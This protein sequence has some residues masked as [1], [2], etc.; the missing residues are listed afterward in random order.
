MVYKNYFP[1]NEEDGGNL[2]FIAPFVDI[3]LKINKRLKNK[4]HFILEIANGHLKYC[5]NKNVY[6]RTGREILENLLKSP[7]YIQLRRR[8]VKN[9]SDRIVQFSKELQKTNLESYSNQKLALIIKKHFRLFMSMIDYGLETAIMELSN[10]LLTNYLESLLRD[11]LKSLKSKKSFIQHPEQS[12]G[13]AGFI[14]YFQILTEETFKGAYN[15]EY[16]DLLKIAIKINKKRPLSSQLKSEKN[17][18]RL[19]KTHTSKYF[20]LDY[21]YQGP[22]L[23]KS[24]FVKRLKEEIKKSPQKSL[25]QI[26]KN[27]KKV[28]IARIKAAKEL[29]LSPNEKHL[30]KAAR[31]CIFIKLY[32]KDAL[33][34]S[35]AVMDKVLV[36]VSKRT[37]YS[38]EQIR[39][40]PA[41][42]VADLIN[43]K[44]SKAELNKRI[45]R[46]VYYF[47]G[48]RPVILTGQKAQQLMK[49]VLVKEKKTDIKVIEGNTACPGQAIGKVKIINQAKD[50]SKM[51][52]GDILVSIATIPEIIPAMKKASAIVTNLGG[53][54]SHAAIVSRE[55][56]TPCVIGTQIA[57]KVLKDGDKV[58]VDA[59]HGTI[60]KI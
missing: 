42:E 47:K 25:K 46:V 28:V 38:L 59:N 31:D 11:K 52:K 13:G 8:K 23:T 58:R 19:I 48:R 10:N 1:A 15:D 35:L 6:K 36:E 5:A 55:L 2:L 56:G 43:Q 33:T 20:W 14:E 37:G 54:T 9:A 49:Q 30:F 27:E 44:I 50:M 24:Y 45:K 22:I 17:L 12:R 60:R 39:Q 40:T 7:Q 21:A 29:K 51:E 26:L 18:Q 3:W 4:I 16:K 34:Y 41:W 53:I 32:R 57:T